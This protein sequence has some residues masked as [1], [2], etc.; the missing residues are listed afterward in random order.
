MPTL[1]QWRA[2]WSA[3]GASA[4][5][6][7]FH[8]LIAS[9]SEPHRRYHAVRH[10]DECL[11]RFAELRSQAD[12]PEE[13]ELAIWF[14]DAVYDTKRKDNE[15]KSAVWARTAV[16]DAGLPGSVAARVHALVMATRHDAAPEGK[17]A[18][19]LVDVDLSILGAAAD[20]FDEYERQIREEYAWVPEALFRRERARI[21]REFLQRE[22]IYDSEQFREAYERRARE[23]LRRSEERLRRSKRSG[24][25]AHEIV[26]YGTVGAVAVAELAVGMSYWIVM[27]SAVAISLFYGFV[28]LPRFRRK[29]APALRTA[30][31]PAES[32]YAVLCSDDEIAVSFE[33]KVRER[34]RWDDIL[35]VGIRIDD[36]FLPQPW[37]VVGGTKGGCW[38]P[39]DAR[40]WE[41]A[42]REMSERLP[43]FD[44]KAVIQ[45][46]GMMSGGVIVWEKNERNAGVSTAQRRTQ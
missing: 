3:L 20:D 28:L 9:Y 24:L 26:F 2:T 5:D 42:H 14:H 46:A 10:L 23:N 44:P 13:V 34:V 21:V 32:K 18:R 6:D 30:R 27:A 36:G 12:H 38:Y 22:H 29:R 31:A 19:L 37:W 45:A 4:P 43:G 16:L 39:S 1:D 35:V 25:P 15:E 17:D 40:G 11:A 7:L 41:I 33:G 8:R